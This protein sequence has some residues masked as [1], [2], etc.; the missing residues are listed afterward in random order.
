MSDIGDLKLYVWDEVLCDYTCGIIF[1]L[2]RDENEARN[3]VKQ[4]IC[5]TYGYKGERC[6]EYWERSTE[7]REMVSDPDVY[8][9]PVG[10][11]VWGGS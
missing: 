1:A 5:E 8:D 10:F 7:N 11:A 9:E 4:N 6:D 3:Q 2:A